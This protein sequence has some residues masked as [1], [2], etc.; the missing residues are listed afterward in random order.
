MTITPR[1]EDSFSLTRTKYTD[2]QAFISYKRYKLASEF[3]AEF[4]TYSQ[5]R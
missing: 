2:L 5:T 3:R 1:I 4:P